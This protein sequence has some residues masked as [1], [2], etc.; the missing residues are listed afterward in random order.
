MA[1]ESEKCSNEFYLK[2]KYMSRTSMIVRVTLASFVIKRN[3]EGAFLLGL[4][5]TI[6]EDEVVLAKVLVVELAD[7]LD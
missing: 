7:H 1:L 6:L 2:N 4:L 5:D 3:R